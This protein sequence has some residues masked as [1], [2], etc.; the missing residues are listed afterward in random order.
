MIRARKSAEKRALLPPINRLKKG[1]YIFGD[2][3]H[4]RTTHLMLHV[5][6]VG[7]VGGV[8]RILHVTLSVVHRTS[9]H[10]YYTRTHA[11]NHSVY[12]RS[13]TVTYR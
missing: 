9:A 10:V 13:S 12:G 3:A 2:V 6:D 11:C 4:T 5:R 1:P 7:N 8:V